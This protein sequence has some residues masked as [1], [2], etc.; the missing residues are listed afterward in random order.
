MAHL[1]AAGAH[2]AAGLANRVVGEVV[3]QDELLPVLATS[4]GIKTL[5]VI[6]STEGGGNQR[7]SFAASK[8][9]RTMSA[10]QHAD[11]AL[12]LAQIAK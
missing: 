9:R 2:D 12:D 11:F 3:V 10:R 1:A 7:L 4:V 8:K 5:R 6:R